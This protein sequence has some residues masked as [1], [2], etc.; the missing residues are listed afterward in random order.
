MKKIILHGILY[1]LSTVACSQDYTN[2]DIDSQVT[3]VQPMT[4]L[5]FW[6]GNSDIETDAISLEF[7]YMDFSQIVLAKSAYDWTVVDELL[8]EMASRNHQAVLRFRF[9]YPGKTTTVPQYIK[10]LADYNETEG[11]TEGMT[12]WFPD[13]TNDEL[14][15]FT[16]EFYEKFA[17]RYANDPRL[18][19][20]QVG[21]GL[22]AEYHIYDGPFELGVTFPD[23]EFQKEF[24][25][26]LSAVLK[27]TFWSISIDAAD[28]TYSPFAAEP[29]LKNL[30]FG[31]FDDSFM[32]AN[33]SGYN[34]ESW[35]FFDRERYKLSPA[36]GEFSYY[37]DYDQ[38]NVLNEDV[39]AYG[40]PYEI[41]A[42]DFHITYINA[43]DQNRYHSL[44]RI[45]EASM[46]SGYKFKLNSVKTKPGSTIIE[47]VNLGVAP[48][49]TDAYLA[50]NGVRSTE[51]LKLLAP[52]EPISITIPEGGENIDVTIESDDI[53]PTETIEY[54]GTV[55]DYERYVQPEE[56]VLGFENKKVSLFSVY[57]TVVNQGGVVKVDYKGIESYTIK[58]YNQL[59]E[60]VY[61]NELSNHSFINTS[62]YNK[63]IYFLSLVNSASKVDS[64][65]FVVK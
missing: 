23:K 24:F 20:L 22:W 29:E 3:G 14:K 50:V 31:L 6:P 55:N 53:L 19:F 49:Y 39:G 26:K 21:F 51:S 10:D 15:R 1:A 62:N 41:Y 8:D 2:V 5:V 18:A 17:G 42:Q 52:D 25:N 60:V 65:K 61:A 34:T 44:E 37:S 45:K 47:I 58:I 13:W 38:E 48:I 12:T 27:E 16:L 33:H 11:L 64:I 9:T 54:F 30:T 56:P 63:G 57:P 43:N 28:D 40:K 4:G 59:G 35:N 36:G 32:H 7:S 46:N